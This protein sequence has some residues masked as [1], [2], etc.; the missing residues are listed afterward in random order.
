[1]AEWTYREASLLLRRAGFGA[2]RRDV[3]RAVRLGRERTVD[4]LLRFRATSARFT[5]RGDAASAARW[6]LRRMLTT[7]SPLQEKLVLFW[8]G[9]FATAISKVEEV[10]LLSIQN[11]TFR[12]LAKG[13]FADLVLAVARD[14]AM[15][16]WLDN[17]DNVKDHP[18]ENFAREL[19][20]LFT[21]GI[22]DLD[23]N[24][25]YTEHD[26]RELARCFTGWSVDSG[27]FAFYPDD[28]DPGEK[29]FSAALGAPPVSGEGDAEAMTSYLAHSPRCAQFLVRKLWA[30]FAYPDPERALVDD[31]AAV[32]LANDTAIEPVLRAM[33]LRDEFTSDR[34]FAEHVSSP[35]EYVVGTLRTLRSRPKSDPLPWYVSDMGQRLYEPPNVAG[36]PGGLAWM[37]S[38]RRLHRHRFAWDVV[39]GRDR[40]DPARTDPREVVRGLPRGAGA[41][42]VVGRV[43]ETLG[44]DAP[45]E[46]RAELVA[47]ADEFAPD[48]GL[49]GPFTLRNPDHVE[50]KVRGLLG[51]ALTS[52]EGL[53]A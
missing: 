52:P 45:A 8:H 49:T 35:V 20:E 23:G 37:T 9:H 46:V 15:I 26:V 50:T 38:V 29:T 42:E 11:G 14:P 3:E 21:L 47:Y 34:A 33:F 10:K 17:F 28:H 18:N 4:T 48:S 44:V 31:L 7:R 32:Y 24:A 36:W 40:H 22:R 39:S 53:L 2:P 41:P 13:R 51:L 12:K 30:H 19:M 1:M 6:W 5:G 43:L 25:N 27:R 16:Y